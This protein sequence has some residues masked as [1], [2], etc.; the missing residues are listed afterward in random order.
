MAGRSFEVKFIGNTTQLSKSLNNLSK[1]AGVVGKSLSAASRVGTAAMASIGASSAFAAVSLGVNAVKAAAADEVEQ[2]KLAKTLRNT[3]GATT[4]QINAIGDYIEKMQF[5]TGVSD[6]EL[7]PAFETLT[8]AMGDVGKAQ[9]TMTLALDIAKG[10]GRDLASVTLGLSKAYGGN[11]ASLMRLG[12]VIPDAIKKTKDFGQVTE[13]LSGLF[14]GQA[15]AYAETFA[16]KVDR[17]RERWGEMVEQIGTAVIPMLM[18]LMDFIQLNLVPA[19]DSIRSAF[20]AGGVSGGFK[21]MQNQIDGLIGKLDGVAK[22]IY[23]ITTFLIGM[24]VAT[25]IIAQ[26]R[27]AFV[28]WQATMIATGSVATA[29]SATIKAALVSTGIGAIVVLVGLLI[30]AF[31]NAYM[32]SETFRDRVNGVFSGL[33][34]AAKG[35]WDW[36]T[37]IGKALGLTAEAA[38]YIDA[39]ALASTRASDKLM[40]V[41]KATLKLGQ[42]A[43][44][45]KQPVTNLAQSISSSGGGSAAKKSVAGASA[46]ATSAIAKFTNALTSAKSNLQSAKDKFADFASGVSQSISSVLDFG[47][48]IEKGNFLAGLEAQASKAA[49]FAG[50]VQQ[51]LAM[52][53]SESGIQQVLAAGADAGSKIADQ[54]IAG[55][56]GAVSRVNELTKSVQAIA[57][58]LGLEGAK[59]FYQAGITQGEALVKGILAALK[60]AG[61]TISGMDESTIKTKGK[62]SK[63][64][65]PKGGLKIPKLSDFAGVAT[66]QPV[67][68][69]ATAQ[70]PITNTFTV[71]VQAGVGDPVAIGKQVVDALQAY[72]LRN[73]TI[74]VRTL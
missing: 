6:S 3:V 19:I 10:T 12:V 11:F 43:A 23:N 25:V 67:P 54:I 34:N 72:Q 63:Y 69:M 70:Q 28:G 32:T 15:S 27:A 18:S 40:N 59:K 1:G 39:A 53:L 49:G 48:A 56:A 44:V 29:M 51:L 26:I 42:A 9:E 31:I 57:D 16:G 14:A 52:G 62:A 7:R 38:V 22:S 20:E 45:A 74:Q 5:A 37:R 64:K 30:Q 68:T 8:R 73:G 41:N 24:K 46:A 4:D 33:I 35:L 55:G 13:Y 21:E 66:A 36:V 65:T 71:N 17:L 60:K 58:Q 2:R 47:G 61:L 50:K